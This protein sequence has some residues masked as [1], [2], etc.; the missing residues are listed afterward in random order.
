MEYI[1]KVAAVV[2]GSVGPAISGKVKT[3]PGPGGIPTNLTAIAGTTSLTINWEDPAGR[4]TG[5]FM[6]YVATVFEKNG[7][8]IYRIF[9][10]LNKTCTVENLKPARLYGIEVRRRNR[11]LEPLGYGG[12]LSEPATLE[13]ETLPAAP[14]SVKVSW[15]PPEGL[16]GTVKGYH[17]LA[18]DKDK[19]VRKLS[20]HARERSVVVTNL[21]PTQKYQFYVQ[22]H[23]NPNNQGMG[24]GLSR[25]VLIPE[26]TSSRKSGT[27]QF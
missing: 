4:A 2:G 10:I 20:V 26:T 23:I 21:D 27:G 8:E 7:H 6:Y 17:I 1:V 5:E 19:I 22:A 9:P 24:G 15:L 12:G 14:S 3:W 13:V 18:K 16:I 25:E 11:H